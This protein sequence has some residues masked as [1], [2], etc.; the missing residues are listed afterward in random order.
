MRQHFCPSCHQKRVAAFGEW[1]CADVLRKVPQRYFIFS[2]PKILS[3]YFLCNWKLPADLRR[4]TRDAPKGFYAMPGTLNTPVTGIAWHRRTV[5]DKIREGF[6]SG[7][8]ED[9]SCRKGG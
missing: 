8:F 9:N 4:H 2:I 1:L 3:H 6:L 5:T 7:A